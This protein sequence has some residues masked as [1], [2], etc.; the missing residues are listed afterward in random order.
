MLEMIAWYGGFNLQATYRTRRFRLTH[1]ICEDVGVVFG[2]AIRQTVERRIP[3]G[4][5]SDGSGFGGIDDAL[6]FAYVVLEG[7]ANH[8]LE[9]PDSLW[10]GDVE[11]AHNTDIV[12]FFEGFAQGCRATVHLRLVAG[13]DRTT[14][15]RLA[16]APSRRRCA[17]RLPQTPG[18]PERPPV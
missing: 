7:R 8:F 17:R 13:G 3:N 2:H 5:A 10:T 15:G 14:G 16:S 1:V 9:L 6:A 18:V 11:D 4:V 12:Q